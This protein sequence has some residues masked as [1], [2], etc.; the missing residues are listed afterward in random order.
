MTQTNV[1]CPAGPRGKQNKSSLGG[2]LK[3]RT[4]TLGTHVLGFKETSCFDDPLCSLN[5]AR[6]SDVQQSGPTCSY[7]PTRPGACHRGG[8]INSPL[9]VRGYEELV[10]PVVLV[11]VEHHRGALRSVTVLQG[12][13]K[14]LESSKGAQECIQVLTKIPFADL[15]ESKRLCRGLGKG[16]IHGQRF[17][18]AKC[19]VLALGHSNPLQL[20]AGVEGLERT[21]GCW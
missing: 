7:D 19:Q 18:K 17:S 21:L 9:P 16:W 14:G 8:G 2:G 4:H 3:S 10:F 6:L 5:I 12:A 20:Q 15:L 1:L 13:Q 11:T